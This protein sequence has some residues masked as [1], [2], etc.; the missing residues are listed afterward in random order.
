MKPFFSL[1]LF[2]LSLHTGAQ[3]M[4]PRMDPCPEQFPVEAIKLAPVPA[5]WV[6][7]SPNAIALTSIELMYGPP[8]E[9]GKRLIGQQRKMRDGFQVVF[10][11][12]TPDPD[13]KWKVCRYG[14]LALAQRMA[15][16]TESCTVSYYRRPAYKNYDI[17]VSC[18]L[19]SPK[20]VQTKPK[21]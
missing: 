8:R 7:I 17:Q 2:M 14:D 10:D 20:A 9:P 19:A 6:G 1:C 16:E 13:G 3:E 5:G 15:D 4:E 18:K 11:V 21:Q 12:S